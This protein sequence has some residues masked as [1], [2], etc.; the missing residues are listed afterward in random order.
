M[1]IIKMEIDTIDGDNIIELIKSKYSIT[2]VHQYE[3]VGILY[4]EEYYMR[5]DSYQLTTII[6]DYFFEF[7]N[8][9][10]ITGGGG[11]GI[12]GI[13]WGSEKSI[14]NRIIN[15]IINYCDQNSIEYTDPE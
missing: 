8:I 3:K 9:K 10:I 5:T 12:L 14:N 7:T 11:S 2:Y 4:L 13:T 1:K 6:I 15:T